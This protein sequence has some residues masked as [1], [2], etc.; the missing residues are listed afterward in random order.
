M[1]L[2]HDVRQPLQNEPALYVQFEPDKLQCHA[3]V[4]GLVVPQAAKIRI[5]LRRALP[6]PELNFEPQQFALDPVDRCG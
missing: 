5:Q 4:A 2:L 6:V 3:R 1:K